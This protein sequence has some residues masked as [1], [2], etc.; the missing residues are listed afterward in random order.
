M[1]KLC[2]KSWL[3]LKFIISCIFR[4]FVES[5][6]CLEE[7]SQA[8]HQVIE[9]RL[10]YIIVVL[11]EK[12]APNKLPPELEVYLTTHTYIDAR[13]HTEELE[14]IRKRIRFAMPKTPRKILLVAIFIKHW[15]RDLFMCEH[16]HIRSYNVKSHWKVQ[17]RNFTH[18]K[19]LEWLKSLI[20]PCRLTR[21]HR[22]K[23]PIIFSSTVIFLILYIFEIS[24]YC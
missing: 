14:T 22:N 2:I 20:L 9:G 21:M 19:R 16:A 4:N 17:G 12:P 8:Y 11:L 15:W 10:N 18:E 23:V 7:F 5:N 3:Y 6:W 13:K 1:C 24:H